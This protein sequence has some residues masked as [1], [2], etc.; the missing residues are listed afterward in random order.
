MLP[1]GRAFTPDETRRGELVATQSEL[2]LI[3]AD[4]F[5]QARERA[6]VDDVT[7]L[8]NARYLLSALDREVSR[9]TRAHGQLSVLFLD[10]D[11][12][13]N[14]NDQFGHLVGS[15]VLMELGQ[16]LHQQIR[17]IDTVGRYGGDEF[18]I[19][20]ADADQDKALEVAERIRRSVEDARFGA[21]RGLQLSLTLSIGVASF[22]GNGET[23]E[24]ILDLA[25]K[26]MYLGKALGRNKVC[27]ANELSDPGPLPGLF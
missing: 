16:L 14:V 20:L 5:V 15:R 24:M 7:G 1:E 10:L 26:A 18:T 9:A 13:K 21:E 4:R 23:S 11:R 17:A 2:A 19:L 8:Y 27:S 6:F 22:P 25:D 12:F 3:N